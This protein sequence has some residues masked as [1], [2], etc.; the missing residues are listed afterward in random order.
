MV[1][2]ADPDNSNRH[3]SRAVRNTATKL[4]PDVPHVTVYFLADFGIDSLNGLFWRIFLR[5]LAS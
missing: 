1:I 3:V 2:V 5:I 4:Q